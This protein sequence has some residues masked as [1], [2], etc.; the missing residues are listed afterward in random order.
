LLL[1]S[2]NLSPNLPVK[3]NQFSVDSQSCPHLSGADAFL[4]GAEKDFVIAEIREKLV[5]HRV[6]Y[7]SRHSSDYANRCTEHH[8]KPRK[9][10]GKG[11]SKGVY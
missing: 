8:S 9:G 7:I 3:E 2:Q 6:E 10:E 1:T 4:K 5:G 11:L